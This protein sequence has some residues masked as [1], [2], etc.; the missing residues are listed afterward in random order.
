MDRPV[1]A[2]LEDA[3][4]RARERRLSAAA[5][6]ERRIAAGSSRAAEIEAGVASAAARVIAEAR[7]ASDARIHAGLAEIDAATR[8]LDA[9]AVADRGDPA[10][11]AAAEMVVGAVLREGRF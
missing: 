6:A 10:I 3:E 4:L 8:A 9:A 1:L 11:E 2:V 5:E 7:A